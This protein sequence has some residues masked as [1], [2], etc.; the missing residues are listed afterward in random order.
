MHH[1]RRTESVGVQNQTPNQLLDYQHMTYQKKKTLHLAG[2]P[3]LLHGVPPTP[4]AS[5]VTQSITSQFAHPTNGSLECEACLVT[6]TIAAD[7]YRAEAVPWSTARFGKVLSRCQTFGGI[8]LRT[9]NSPSNA[10]SRQLNFVNKTGGNHVFL[11]MH[12]AKQPFQCRQN[13]VD[14]FGKNSCNEWAT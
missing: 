2:H 11:K 3:K 13:Y 7:N 1:L 12:S 8:V 14:V 4:Q 5:L 9:A 10:H 6:F